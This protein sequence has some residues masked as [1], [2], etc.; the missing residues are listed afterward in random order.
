MIYSL[1]LSAIIWNFGTWYFGLPVSSTHSLIGS[2]L[3]VSIAFGMANGFDITQSV[4]W[5]VAYGVLI[6]LALS[7]LLGFGMS[8]LMMKLSRKYITDNKFFAV[9][10]Q[11]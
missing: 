2:I 9:L 5:K 11:N 6:A 10:P 4:N 7:P 3:G 8:Y 1:L